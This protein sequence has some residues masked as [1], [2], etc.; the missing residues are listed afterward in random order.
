VLQQARDEAHRF[1][2]T[3]QRKRR[4]MRTITSELLRIPGVGE[5]KRR[6]LLETFGS[7]QGV[8]EASPEA[9]AALP[10]FGQ[11]TAERILELLRRSEPT[12]PATNPE[13]TET[14]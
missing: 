6:K 7:L 11:K 10:G 8:R 5:S 13:P 4:S 12:A 9:I 14:T 2:I 3:F 1:A